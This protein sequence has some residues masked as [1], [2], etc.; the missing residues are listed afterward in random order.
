MG[1]WLFL[2]VR[3]HSGAFYRRHTFEQHVSNP[4]PIFLLEM[5]FYPSFSIELIPGSRG[6]G[7]ESARPIL[8]KL[9][10]L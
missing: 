3:K 4:F 8:F 6:F 7:D 5:L 10:I 9:H 1:S 2:L